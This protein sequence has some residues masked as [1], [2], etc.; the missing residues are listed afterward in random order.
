MVKIGK[1]ATF[2]DVQR[3]N[4]LRLVMQLGPHETECLRRKFRVRTRLDEQSSGSGTS[5]ETSVVRPYDRGTGF[6]CTCCDAWFSGRRKRARK[7]KGTLYIAIIQWK[8][9]R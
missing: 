7:A 5:K 4:H 1:C 3:H 6:T 8:G 2:V 9:L